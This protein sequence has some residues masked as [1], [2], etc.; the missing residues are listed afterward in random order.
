[1]N[2]KPPPE[3]S[4]SFSPDSRRSLRKLGLTDAQIVELEKV[5]PFCRLDIED[6]PRLEDVRDELLS[7]ERAIKSVL[8]RV[9][10]LRAEPG[11]LSP[12]AR[13]AMNRVQRASCAEIEAA[14]E[15]LAVQEVEGNRDEIEAA[16]EALN[17][18]HAAGGDRVIERAAKALAAMDR[19]IGRALD[20][21]GTEQRRTKAASP[22]PIERIYRAL[23]LGSARG[24]SGA[25]NPAGR[26]AVARLTTAAEICYAAIGASDGYS[27]E[28]AIK[29]FRQ[30][31]RDEA[32]QLDTM[33]RS[34]EDTRPPEKLASRP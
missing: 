15:A 24:G 21:L 25:F 6:A 11:T 28:R 14:R 29:A 30:L 2:I 34:M 20:D 1:V 32:A 10:R 9:Q 22:R 27:P 18:A 7:T 23:L 12:A 16:R 19:V 8:R 13:E 4:Y 26:G 33:V 5:L 31:Q 17:G 3:R